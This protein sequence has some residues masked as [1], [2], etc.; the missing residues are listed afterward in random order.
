MRSALFY[1]GVAA[2]GLSCLALIGFSPILFDWGR[3]LVAAVV[4]LA[5]VVVGML[6]RECIRTSNRNEDTAKAVVGPPAGAAAA[7]PL[8]PR[9]R[10][11][12][13]L[14]AEGLS[15]KQMARRLALSD[16]TV[17]THL[18]NTYAKLGVSGRVEAVIAAQGL[19]LMGD[20]PKVTHPGD[21]ANASTRATLQPSPPVSGAPK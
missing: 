15:N 17:K 14:L 21:G 9:E 1:G 2:L 3:E 11:V 19:G 10:E 5:G 18:A 4:A 12:V 8:S 16:N 20:H 13:R 6:V 7:V